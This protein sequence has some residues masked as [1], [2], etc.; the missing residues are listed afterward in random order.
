M[1]ASTSAMPRFDAAVAIAA[2]AGAG[3][4]AGAGAVVAADT[5]ADADGLVVDSDADRAG[6]VVHTPEYRRR[7]RPKTA[8]GWNS[9][10]LV[11]GVLGEVGWLDAFLEERSMDGWQT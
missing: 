3:D 10:A 9:S 11:L 2:G 7:I 4:G 6:D 8:A 1:T 5:D